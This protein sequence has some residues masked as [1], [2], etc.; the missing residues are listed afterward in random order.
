MCCL[1]YSQYLLILSTSLSSIFF[2]EKV[3]FY[4]SVLKFWIY[5]LI[6]RVIVIELLSCIF[7]DPMDWSPPGS[8]VHGIS[9]QEHWD[10]LPFPSPG[11][12]PYPEIKPALEA[13]S[14]P[15]SHQRSPVF[16]IV[17]YNFWYTGH[18]LIVLFK[19]DIEMQFKMFSRLLN[20]LYS[21]GKYR[22]C[23]FF[24][25]FFFKEK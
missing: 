14:S 1:K 22:I 11:D 5:I 3:K 9:R 21:K 19:N 4:N 13:D 16:I 25:F 15:L 20:R 23:L 18:Y 7:C 10:G 24:F 6:Y 2:L 17:N 12:L 8:S